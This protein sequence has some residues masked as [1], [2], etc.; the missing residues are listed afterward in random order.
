M[1][2][3]IVTA[4]YNREKLLPT[5]YESIK[6]NYDTFSDFEWIIQDDGSIDQTKQLVRK[7][8]K[9]V[10]FPIIYHFQEN[11]GKMRAINQAMLFVT[12]DIVLEVDSDDYLLDEALLQIHQDYLHLQEENVYGILYKRRLLGKNTTVNQELDNQVVSLFDLHNRYGYDFDMNLTFK[13][14]IRKKYS[15]ILEDEEKFVTE[16]R[17]YYYLDQ[18]Y[19]GMKF[20]DEEIVVGEY[21]TDGYSKNIK[22]MFKKY[23]KGYYAFFRECLGYIKKNTLF[24]RKLYFIKHYILFSYLTKKSIKECI[25]EASF[26][27]EWITLLVIPGYIKASRF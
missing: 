16:A 1:K 24:K 12:G 7:W 6:K 25:K 3:S 22:E 27:K 21:L 5:L 11:A 9:E 26:Y 2:I 14:D 15:Y 18:L 17:L 23:P 20:I 8:T 19:D 13:A 10:Y 4:T